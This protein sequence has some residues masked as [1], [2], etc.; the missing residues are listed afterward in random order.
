[1]PSFD[2]L[3]RQ[4]RKQEEEN[5]QIRAEL[6]EAH[7]RAEAERERAQREVEENE[8]MAM[9]LAR[10]EQELVDAYRVNDQLAEERDMY[11]AKHCGAEAALK[12]SQLLGER[13]A[14]HLEQALRADM[15][16]RVSG[17]FVQSYA[18]DAV[19]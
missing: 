12:G 2:R 13:R 7:A 11:R 1:M 18:V 16:N 10:T 14:Q 6:E 17:P 19:F 3:S 9:L 15:D 8:V 4:L 5:A